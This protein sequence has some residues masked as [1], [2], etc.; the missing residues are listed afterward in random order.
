VLAVRNLEEA[1]FE[2]NKVLAV[3]NLEEAEREE[4]EEEQLTEDG[5]DLIVKEVRARGRLPNVSYFAFTA[6][7]KDKTLQL[8]GVQKAD[9]SY[10]PF[11]LYSMKQAIEEGFILD[12]LQN[13]VTYKAYWNLLKKIEQDPRYEKGKASAL[14]RAFVDIN[15]HV[16]DKKVAV[17]VEH[18]AQNT[19]QRIGGKAK[20]MIVTRSRLHAVRYKHAMDRY[21]K[22]HGY[23]YKALVAFSGTVQDFTG[24]YTESEMNDRIPESQTAETFKQDEYRFLIV[25]NKF[26]T[27]FDQPLLHTMYVDK[28]L[29]GVNAV[30]TLSR[31][32]RV[33]PGKQETMV[34]DF[35]NDAEKIQTSFAPYFVKTF[36][37]EGI[38]P[39]LLYD[40]ET[41]LNDFGFYTEDEV[42]RAGT[43]WYDPQETQASIHTILDTVRARY[44]E[45]HADQRRD[46]RKEL[47][48]YIRLYSFLV[49]INTFVDVGLEKLYI[50]SRFLVR[51][52]PTPDGQFPTEILQYIDI[53]S[54]RLQQ[55]TNGKIALEQQTEGLQP[56]RTK[57]TR[58]VLPDEKEP[59]S[60]IIQRLNEIAGGVF[61]EEDK[62]C[63]E[64][65]E[66]RLANSQA[67]KASVHVNPPDGVRLVFEEVLNDLLQSMMEGNLKFYKHVNDDEN[68]S[69]RFIDILFDRY[70]KEAKNMKKLL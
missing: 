67:L 60:Q 2:E 40:T 31:L 35:A 63:I 64:E 18:F 23:P 33:Y 53:D 65:L 55:T 54:Y 17:I 42:D 69:K 29:G 56:M 8:F 66:T 36:L 47:T 51:K 12:V 14:L 27:G 15:E 41:R 7:P 43:L 25:A 26:Q 62:V 3:R 46:F 49:Q 68:F 38:D 44:Q 45:A 61:T 9:G 39:N 5:E 4:N 20:A 34:L 11:S 59:L 58:I 37:A 1:E 32:N 19:A 57:R 16:I 30:Q 21:L 50:F 52:L 48:D 10:E 24:A 13:Y 28:K 70:M 22:A 6:T